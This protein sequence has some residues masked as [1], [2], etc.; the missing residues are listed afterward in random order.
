MRRLGLRLAGHLARG[1]GMIW[2]VSTLTFFLVRLLPGDPISRAYERLMQQ[3]M[4]P[5]PAER[6]AAVP[7]GFSAARHCSGSSTST[8]S[9]RLVRFDLGRRYGAGVPVADQVA[10]ATP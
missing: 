3:G 1:L 5:E 4:S 7:Y 2:V 8:I 10:A 9:G 6:Q